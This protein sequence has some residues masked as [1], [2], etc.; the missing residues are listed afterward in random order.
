M[1]HLARV[2]ALARSSTSRHCTFNL[3]QVIC[4]EIEFERSQS[5]PQTLAAARPHQRYDILR[6]VTL[7]E[8]APQVRK[9]ET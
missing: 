6:D 5:L 8:D 3:R 1:G 7:G 9:Q 2:V 4:G